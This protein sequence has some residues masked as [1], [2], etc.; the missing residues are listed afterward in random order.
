MV[1]LAREGDGEA[2]FALLCELE[3]ETLDR[4][5]FD[6]IFTAHLQSEEGGF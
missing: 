1:R 4:R 3:Q 5:A 6:R 2:V